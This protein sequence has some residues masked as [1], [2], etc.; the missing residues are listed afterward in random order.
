MLLPK[1]RRLRYHLGEELLKLGEYQEAVDFYEGLRQRWPKDPRAAFSLAKAY[2]YNRA[3]EDAARSLQEALHLDPKASADILEVGDV[4]YDLKE[5]SRAI[6]LYQKAL[7]VREDAQ[8]RYKLALSY[9]ETGQPEK[10]RQE[11]AKAL[12]GDP[13]NRDFQALVKTLN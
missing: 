8:A 11:A 13:E 6:S 12:A 9:K 3:F 5:Y 1:D 4:F 7:A 10:A 2:T